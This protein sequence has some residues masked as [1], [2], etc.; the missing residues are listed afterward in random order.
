MT[1]QRNTQGAGATSTLVGSIIKIL[2]ASTA[3]SLA[4]P[5]MAEDAGD[6]R[7][8]APVVQTATAKEFKEGRRSFTGV[9]VAR[10]QSDLGF[11]VNGKVIERLVDVG[12]TVS[13]GQ[14]LLRLDDTDLNLALRAKQNSVIS[15]KAAVSR[16]GSDEQRY[17]R[18]LSA[19]ATSHQIYDEAKQAYDTAVA[20]LD[21]ALAD[22]DFAANEATYS[23]LRAD[24]DGIVTA[25][26]AEPGQVVTAGQSVIKLAHSGDREASVNLPE[27]VR[28]SIGSVG[29]ASMYGA[30]SRS[31]NVRLRQLSNAAD[32][33]T[34]TFEARYVLESNTDV[35]LGSTV[36]VSI[37]EQ[38]SVTPRE[39]VQVP[40][41]SLWDSG[42]GSGV[43]EVQ[44]DKTVQF[45]PV[46]VLSLGD[47]NAV[48]SG[49]AT[50]TVVVAVGVNFLTNGMEIRSDSK[51]VASK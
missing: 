42:N 37:E 18:L 41:G 20:Q 3:L 47:E 25:T 32:P 38:S 10:V 26:A 12:Q 33:A 46:K 50:G 5:V 9:V 36:K 23:T 6:P 35:P 27:T 39:A 2:I 11:R 16:T 17:S 31:V 40:I 48:V 45:H 44:G 30:D 13:R 29:V 4:F 14:A 7:L 24:A 51:E 8:K 34:R 19:G 28:P 15:A 22:A 1:F 49:I 43:W 21:A